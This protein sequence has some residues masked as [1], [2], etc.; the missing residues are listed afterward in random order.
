MSDHPLE[1]WHRLVRTQ[2][3]SGLQALLA[4]D[5]VFYSPVVHTAQHGR[6]LAATVMSGSRL[7][8]SA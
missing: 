8:R 1:T 5:A 6:K 2:D 7:F 3:P 4:E